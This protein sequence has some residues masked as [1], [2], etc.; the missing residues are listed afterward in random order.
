MDKDLPNFT[1]VYSD[2]DRI[3]L[4]LHQT[5]R[6]SDARIMFTKDGYY[7]KLMVESRYF[8]R[9]LFKIEG[10]TVY[11]KRKDD[12]NWEPHNEIVSHAILLLID[13][14]LIETELLK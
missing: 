11:Y 4:R 14:W 2:Q 9:E 5:R 13:P 6:W 3:I 10:G 7:I 1:V 8:S 12:S